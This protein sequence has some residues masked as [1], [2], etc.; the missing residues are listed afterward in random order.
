VLSSSS[1]IRIVSIIEPGADVLCGLV[2]FFSLKIAVQPRDT[3]HLSG[4]GK[5]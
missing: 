3:D 1:T 4:H 5:A 2:V